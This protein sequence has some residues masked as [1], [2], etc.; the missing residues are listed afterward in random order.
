MASTCL[1]AV[2]QVSSHRR[3]PAAALETSCYKLQVRATLETSHRAAPPH[4]LQLQSLDLVLVPSDQV[5]QPL[6]EV[7]SRYPLVTAGVPQ[8]PEPEQG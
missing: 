1:N 6:G 3:L 4:Y 8:E 5:V 2:R 7:Q